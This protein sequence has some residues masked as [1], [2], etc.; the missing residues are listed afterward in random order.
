MHPNMHSPHVLLE[1]KRVELGLKAEGF[2][3]WMSTGFGAVIN[4]NVNIYKYKYKYIYIYIYI[5]TFIFIFICKL[6]LYSP[7]PL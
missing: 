3:W 2:M 1:V 5:F 7:L 6:Y 4:I